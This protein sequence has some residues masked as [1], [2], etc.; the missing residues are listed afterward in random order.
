MSEKVFGIFEHKALNRQWKL[1]QGFD[2][3]FLAPHSRYTETRKEDLEQV[4]ELEVLAESDEAG[5]YIAASKDGKN[6]FVLGHS[7]YDRETLLEE[8]KRDKERGLE[9]K[10]PKN[11]FPNDNA[12][13]APYLTWRAHSNL[14]FTNWLNYY[15][16]Q[17]TPYDFA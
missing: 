10:Q 16:Y 4:K 7:E 11:Y 8:Y 1:L 14:L 2:D 17:E 15:V 3:L 6:I 12:N 13:L 5:V 9:T